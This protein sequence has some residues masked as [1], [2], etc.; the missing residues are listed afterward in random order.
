MCKE[1]AKSPAFNSFFLGSMY[2]QLYQTLNR[3]G[4]ECDSLYSVTIKNIT[5]TSQYTTFFSPTHST[6]IGQYFAG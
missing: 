4:P 2:D 6:T 5:E 1:A 3:R